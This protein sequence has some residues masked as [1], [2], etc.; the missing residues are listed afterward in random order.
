MAK[1]K[2][3]LL[4]W[5]KDIWHIVDMMIFR[6]LDVVDG[7]TTVPLNELHVPGHTVF[8]DQDPDIGGLTT[9]FWK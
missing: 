6:G 8:G 1:L 5:C 9:T 3:N 2:I 4:T 7:Y